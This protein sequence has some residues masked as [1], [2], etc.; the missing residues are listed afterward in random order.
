MS[1]LKAFQRPFQDL[2][3]LT[4]GAILSGIPVL[5]V[6]T[7]LF[8]TGYTAE[9][10]R[11]TFHQKNNLPE[12]K[13]FLELFKNGFFVSIIWIVYCL[14]LFLVLLILLFRGVETFLQETN[15]EAFTQHLLQQNTYYLLLL[16]VLF[17]LTWYIALGAVF[18]YITHYRFKDENILLGLVYNLFAGYLT[19][20]AATTSMT[21]VGEAWKNVNKKRH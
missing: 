8:V 5:N 14:P 18:R 16:A 20:I 6:L 17:L 21:I 2:K 15:P 9:C 12:W 10:A 1:Y 4:L 19:F 13:N 11:L 7:G 3:K